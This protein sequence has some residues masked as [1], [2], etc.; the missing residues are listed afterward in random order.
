MHVDFP[1]RKSAEDVLKV[2]GQHLLALNGALLS[3]LP[4]SE[5]VPDIVCK[6]FSCLTPLTTI[7]R[8]D[9]LTNDPL[10]AFGVR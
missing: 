9:V 1:I 7:H 2:I 6:L 3:A 5:V 8:F 10:V 4:V